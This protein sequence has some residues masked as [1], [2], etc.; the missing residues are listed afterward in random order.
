MLSRMLLAFCESVKDVN[1]QINVV[2]ICHAGS[3]LDLALVLGLIVGQGL[4]LEAANA[5]PLA[6]HSSCEHTSIQHDILSRLG[7]A[8]LLAVSTN[9]EK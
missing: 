7:V 8:M 3:G 5:V 1:K 2:L 9:S 6:L 4:W